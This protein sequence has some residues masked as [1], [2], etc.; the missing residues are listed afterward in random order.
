MRRLVPIIGIAL[1]VLGSLV[2]GAEARDCRDETPLPADVK[3][4]A[5]GADV[6]PDAARFAGAW[7]GPWKAPTGD[8]VCGTLVVE[9]VLPT[10]HARVVYSHGTWAPG[11][12]HP[13]Y[14]R[15]TG[16][17][18]D[19]ELRFELPSQDRPPMVYRFTGDAV[20]G[21][22]R[23]GGHHA[24][25]RVADV[26]GIG[27]RQ[28]FS[29]DR[30]PPTPSGPR[31]RL[32][33]AELLSSSASGPLHHDYFLPVGP[34]MPARHALR[35]TIRLTAQTTSY[36]RDGCLGLTVAMPAIAFE[37]FTHGDHIVPVVR[38][39]TGS[40]ATIILSPGRI[41]SEPGDL[42]MS[43]AS[44]P[45]V[46]G[47]DLGNEAYNGVATFLFDD[48][49]VSG[50]RFQIGQETAPGTDLVDYWGAARASYTPGTIADEMTLRARF[51]E[52]VRRRVLIR[53]WSDLPPAVRNA[54]L[55][56]VDGE[57]ATDAVS[58]S[59]IVIDGV[60]YLRGCN[61]RYGPFPYCREMRHGVFSVTKSLGGAVALLR[62]A[63]KYGDAV[64]DAKIQDHV[65]VT[66]SHDGWKDVTFA[67]ALGMT[68]GIGELSPQREPNNWS[69]DE[70]KP[71]FFAWFPKRS[72]AEKLVASFEYPKYPWPRGE[73]FRYNTTQTFVLAAAMDAYLK[74]REGP[75]A[76]LWDMVAR[77][78][79][80]PI[81]AFHVPTLHTLERDGSRGVPLLG[82]GLFLTVDDVAKLATLLQ[83]GGRH[84]GRQI[85]SAA[86]LADALY[87]TKPDA[88]L[89]VG[90]TFRDGVGRYHLSFWSMPY[91][92][93]AGCL[94]RVPFMWGL[95]GNF[96]ALLPNGVS[97]FRFT[98]ATRAVDVEGMI[99]AGEA[100]RPLCTPAAASVT[101]PPRAPLDARG[102]RA[103][104]TGHTFESPGERTTF[105]RRGFVVGELRGGLDVGRWEVADDGHYCLT[106]NVWD[107]ARR[108][109]HRVYQ[110][111]E[112]LELYSVDRWTV[113]KMRRVSTP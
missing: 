107:S 50:V 9:E 73:V 41:W 106:W 108:R 66:A 99:L 56:G 6:P 11:I 44:F 29:P 7:V 39:I 33:A 76:H 78:V 34:W 21:T 36:A 97:T 17:V 19:G 104:L 28:R 52:E 80:E 49:R 38:G 35:G 63:Q 37:F 31:D 83:S 71:R 15:A 111:A 16:R 10:G 69:A 90:W 53:P 77:E 2:R 14:W 12:H 32:T 74:R 1:L 85:L 84:D 22:Y 96:V 75:H 20:S 105:D 79:L 92:A 18:V 58:A 72:A 4:I 112:G 95:G 110:T 82:F 27:C 67:D 8:I 26:A 42:G 57:V 103:A 65:T 70:S 113:I 89:P 25:T 13:R 87:R 64:L 91:R 59:G 86:K 23:G 88:G 68:T 43:R 40:P 47:H 55:G 46:H 81:G 30:A 60:L 94:V 101:A 51:D 102:V 93:S 54:P 48:T 45:F 98:D 5:P 61:T 100:V 109:C 24:V 3:L 62:L